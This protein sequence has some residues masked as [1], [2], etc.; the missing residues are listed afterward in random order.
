MLGAGRLGA[1]D[2]AGAITPAGATWTLDWWVGAEDR[3]HVPAAEAAVRQALV[4]STPVVETRMRVPGGDVVH[5]A[6]GATGAGAVAALVVEVE[7]QTPTPVAVALVVHGAPVTAGGDR[8]LV[9]DL[10][11]R[12]P[13]AP[14][15]FVAPAAFVPL[16]HRATLRVAL[17]GDP[18]P[19][20]SL[21]PAERVVAG[22]RRQAEDAPR[23]VVPDDGL[24]QAIDAARAFLH[25]HDRADL[26]ATALL[27]RAAAAWGE[28][29]PTYDLAAAQR[30][31]GGVEDATGSLAATGQA[32]VAV[33]ARP[34]EPD[35]ELAGAVAKAVHWIERKRMVRRHRK[36]ALR[37]RLL[38]A[39]PQPPILGREE[40]LYWDDWWSIAGDAAAAG[41]L[42]ELNQ[43]EAAVDAARFARALDADVDRSITARNAQDL[44]GPVPAGPGRPL[45]AGIVGLV[46]AAALGAV[47]LARPRVQATLDLVRSELA[48]DAGGIAP[49]VLGSGTSPW[50]TALLAQVELAVGEPAGWARLCHLLGLGRLPGVWPELVGGEPAVAVELAGHHPLATGAFLVA[51]RSLLLAER[52]PFLGPPDTVALL[53]TFPAAWA[54]QA[55]EAHE[56]PTRLGTVGFAVR[57]HGER[58]ALLWEVGNP[59]A[60]RPLRLVAPGLD[61]DWT[62]TDPSGEA[63]LAPFRT[64]PG[65]PLA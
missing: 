9:E 52:G 55:V 56:L 51:A 49:G 59:P 21:A 4:G 32:L 62:T 5:R 3:W 39:G 24:A 61:P 27:A 63:L 10:Q 41:L 22:W 35:E 19:L 1:V 8:L 20:D 18:P 45:D 40:L 6:Y 15:G 7:N 64:A 57:W 31:L 53:P 58:P 30:L 37:A 26:L 54:G 25:L 14:G 12:L 11:V 34:G 43:V 2:P 17:A 38:P 50:L 60:D 33:A 46:A 28:E 13:R 47:D 36:D 48:D 42:G 29:A 65:G 23:V 16:A 44:D